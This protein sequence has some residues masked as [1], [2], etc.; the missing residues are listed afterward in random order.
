MKTIKCAILDDDKEAL[1]VLRG[2]VANIDYLEL[3]GEYTDVVEAMAYIRNNPID[4]LFMGIRMQQMSGLELARILPKRMRLVFVTA[5]SEYAI[6]GYKV[7]AFDYLLKP[8]SFEDFEACVKRVKDYIHDQDED[9]PIRRDGFMFVKS[10]YKTIRINLSDV[11]YIEG[12][13]DYVKFHMTNNANVITLMNMRELENNLPKRFF[14]RVHR[15]FIAN[16]NLF[17]YTDKTKL[18]YG[19]IGI[20]ISDTYRNAVAEFVAGHSMG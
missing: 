19:T 4:L 2:H 8:L 3:A 16:L 13:K 7:G 6:E 14:Q 11:Q 10:D 1:E 5:H 17:D 18:Y 9:D 20:P 15:S 12:V